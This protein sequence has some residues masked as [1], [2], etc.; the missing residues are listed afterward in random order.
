[1]FDISGKPVK[2]NPIRTAQYPTPAARPAYSVMDK[3][4]VKN[5]FGIRIPYWRHSLQECIKRLEQQQ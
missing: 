3:A 2:V 4:K 1:V 5:A